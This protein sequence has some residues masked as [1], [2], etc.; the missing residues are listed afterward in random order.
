MKTG[1]QR[2]ASVSRR[3]MVFGGNVARSGTFK[4]F[5]KTR[6]IS[7]AKSSKQD[8]LQKKY[9]PDGRT[10]NGGMLPSPPKRCAGLAT[11]SADQTGNVCITRWKREVH[12]V[13]AKCRPFG[14]P[15]T[16][17]TSGAHFHGRRTQ[18]QSCSCRT[19]G[20]IRARCEARPYCADLKLSLIHI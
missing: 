4:M 2:N 16:F 18:H 17:A 3:S 8:E 6:A 20:T 5:A 11:S 13:E 7:T 12:M 9:Y 1:Q 19:S 15:Q 14:K 10:V